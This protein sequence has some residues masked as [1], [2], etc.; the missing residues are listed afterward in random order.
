MNQ[1]ELGAAVVHNLYCVSLLLALAG[2]K[3]LEYC[4]QLV[5]KRGDDT[6]F[7]AIVFVIKFMCKIAS[8]SYPAN[9]PVIFSFDAYEMT[10]KF[11]LHCW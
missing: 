1:A 4:D 7:L 8:P 9:S 5:G 10:R 6:S 2:K 3:K 11:T